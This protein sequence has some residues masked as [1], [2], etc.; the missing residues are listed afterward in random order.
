[1]ALFVGEFEQQVDAKHRLAIP[2]A[3]RELI[4]AEQDGERFYLVLSSERHLLLYPSKYYRRLVDVLDR[5]P[6]PAPESEAAG[7]D[8]LWGIARM[9]KPDKQGRIVLP[10]K[11]LERAE[12]TDKVML[13]GEMDRIHIWPRDAW[14]AHVEKGLPSYGKMLREA[15]ARLRRQKA[16]ASETDG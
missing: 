9:V 11:S 15:A 1:M 4:D 13:V 16:P 5:S 10:E 8:L 2:F 14:N 7:M 12:L 3:L 6:L